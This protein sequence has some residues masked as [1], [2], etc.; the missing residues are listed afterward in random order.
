MNQLN[1]SPTD[2]GMLYAVYY[3]VLGTTLV[4]G[5]FLADHYDQKRIIILGYLL[6]IPVPFLLASATDWNQLWLPMVLYGT[7]FGFPSICL[8]VLRSVP[9]EKTMQA[10]G[11]LSAAIAAGYVVSPFIGGVLSS[12]LGKQIV[13]IIAAGFFVASTFPLIF[14]GRL[15]KTTPT[16]SDTSNKFSLIHLRSKKLIKL[17]TFFSLTI[18][19][20]FLI[21]PLITQFMYST[22][23]QNIINLGL[24][25]T[26]TSCGWI[27][28]SFALGKIGDNYSKTSAMLTSIAVS[29]FFFLSNSN[30]KQF[31]FS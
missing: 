26:V 10:F 12:S 30:R 21:K 25:G 15:P 19:A 3:L 22:Y 2:V 23:D 6:W 24:F 4:V 31:L 20:V 8:Y 9:R 18:F 28:F 29:S 17:C 7:F 13:F 1:A 5:G 14:L 11:F 27:F 16:K